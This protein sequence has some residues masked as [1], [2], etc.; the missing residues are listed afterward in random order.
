MQHTG[1]FWFA[2][3]VAKWKSCCKELIMFF[4]NE[5]KPNTVQH[6]PSKNEAN[7]EEDVW[8]RRD[9]SFNDWE[10][11]HGS[12]VGH[13]DIRELCR[14]PI[15]RNVQTKIVF[16]RPFFKHDRQNDIEWKELNSVTFVLYIS[17]HN[18]QLF[19]MCTRGGPELN[20]IM[21]L[22]LLFELR[23]EQA[24]NETNSCD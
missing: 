24:S 10:V 6:V 5:E 12:R 14:A 17:L 9:G 7:K 20:N 2:N 23:K 13:A 8:E 11:F 16:L 19:A 21:I 15:M 3:C 1:A 4:Q 18:R 22:G